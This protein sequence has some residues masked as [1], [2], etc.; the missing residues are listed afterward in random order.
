MKKIVAAAILLPW[1]SLVHQAV[2][3]NSSSEEAIWKIKGDNGKTLS[4]M[5][6]GKNNTCRIVGQTR[7]YTAVLNNKSTSGCAFGDLY[8]VATT[9]QIWQQRDTGT[10]S[11]NAYIQK[12][13][14]SNGQYSTIDIVVGGNTVMRYPIGYWSTQK[15]FSGKNKPRW[16]P[17]TYGQ[18][19]PYKMTEQDDRKFDPTPFERQW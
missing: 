7:H 8:I 9:E 18:G 16:K 19:G 1:L 17:K 15:E 11:P 10:C 2:A 14:I 13:T 4:Q 3:A 12:G 5:C 6:G